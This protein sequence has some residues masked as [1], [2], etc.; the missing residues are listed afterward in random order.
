[1]QETVRL[2]LISNDEQVVWIQYTITNNEGL[3]IH[4]SPIRIFWIKFMVLNRFF[5]HLS[6]SKQVVMFFFYFWQFIS[7][8]MNGL[9]LFMLFL[10]ELG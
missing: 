5:S 7:Y 8:T 1:M 3:T 9:C 4:H 10:A 6:N 2:C